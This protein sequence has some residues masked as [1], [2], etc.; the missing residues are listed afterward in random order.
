MSMTGSED[1]KTLK[2]SFEVAL[3]RFGGVMDVGVERMLA[4]ICPPSSRYVLHVFRPD[5]DSRG[6]LVKFW[7]ECGNQIYVV[8]F[9]S[10]G[11]SRVINICDGASPVA[12]F[13]SGEESTLWSAEATW[14]F[15]GAYTSF[16]CLAPPPFCVQV[17]GISMC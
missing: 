8:C 4:K 16:G 1:G 13:P 5:D 6:Y 11:P 15:G 14:S 3:S 17:E 9:G 10:E 2:H 7:F 12:A